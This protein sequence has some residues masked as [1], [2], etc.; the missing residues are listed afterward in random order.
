MRQRGAHA[1]VCDSRRVRPGD[2]LVAWPGAAQD[3]RRFVEAALAAGAVACLVE[4]EGLDAWGFADPRIAAVPGLKAAAGPLA[5][6]FHGAPSADVRVVALTGT[7]GK[8]STAWWTAQWLGA[9]GAPAAVMGTL[10]I[11]VPGEA[12]D[13]T[14]LT[15]PDPV[16]L[17]SALRQLHGRG[18]RACVVEASSIGLAEGR[19][20]GTAVH[21]AVFTNFTQD[22][23][24]YHGSMADYWQAKRALFDWPG[25]RAAVV[26]L[27]DPQGPGLARE[28]APRG[29][30]LWTVSVD[31][32]PDADGAPA[33]LRVTERRWTTQGIA[34]T[35][36]EAGGGRATLALPVVGDYNL[37]N[38]LCALAVARAQGH[39]LADAAAASAA[40]TPV[41]GRMQSAWPDGPTELPLVLVDYAHT[42]DALDKALQALQPVA[43]E[44]GGRLWCVVGCGGDRDRTKRPLMAAAAEREAA[45][46]VLTSDNPRSEDPLTILHQM[47]AGL[48][49]PVRAVV[50]PDRAQAIALAVRLA[51]ARDVVLLAGKGHED[52]QD[53]AGVQRPFSDLNEGRR[54]LQA[55]HDATPGAAA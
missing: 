25:L 54:A 16:R 33:R 22:H 12:M 49:E 30:A 17:Q 3:G 55:R 39:G 35:V 28:L 38:L 26:N 4:H 18:V 48:S 45:R 23:L 40:L 7:N 42:P 41:P 34:F 20:N 8:T 11:G 15:T 44:R 27:D 52:Y 46:V 10:G 14:G 50:E 32:T 37:A 5:A 36:E 21:T 19:L 51:D 29:L 43:R 47:Q 53:V 24:D 1:L 13:P 9:L 31:G 6:A 2:A